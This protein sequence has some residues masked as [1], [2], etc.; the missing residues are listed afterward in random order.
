M[1]LN[2]N[3]VLIAGHLTRDPAVKRLANDRTVADFGLA[4]NR[5]YKGPDGE[6]KEDATFVDIEAWGR[7]AELAGQYLNKGSPCFVEGRLKYETW[8][9][10]DGTRRTTLKVVAENI[11]FLRNKPKSGEEESEAEIAAP[12]AD[13]VRDAEVGYS[14]L[15]ESIRLGEPAPF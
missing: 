2:L 6:L 10:K 13:R 12:S 11:Q 14:V 1:A 4:I 15:P 3:T 7:T 5:R 8:Q 9:A